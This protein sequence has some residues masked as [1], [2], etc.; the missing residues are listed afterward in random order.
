M[1][2]IEMSRRLKVLKYDDVEFKEVFMLFVMTVLLASTLS[3]K[4]ID[5][6]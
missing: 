5:H 4:Q 2:Y 6:G 3:C 1:T